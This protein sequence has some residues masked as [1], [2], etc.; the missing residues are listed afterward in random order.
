ME[1]MAPKWLIPDKA[2]DV[3]KWVGLCVCPAIAVCFGA[4][5]P[6]W[7]LDAG[8]TN[9]VVLTINAVGTCIGA[10]IGASAAKNYISGKE[11]DGGDGEGIGK[12]A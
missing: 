12:A 6:S 3:L 10:V 11:G 1:D 5:A 8:T 9:A 7:G 2:Y 4:V